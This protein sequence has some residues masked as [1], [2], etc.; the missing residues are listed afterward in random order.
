MSD[1]VVWVT[2]QGFPAI[3][4]D[5]C[6]LEFCDFDDGDRVEICGVIIVIQHGHVK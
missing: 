5:E 4:A 2:G 3:N 1:G 6:G